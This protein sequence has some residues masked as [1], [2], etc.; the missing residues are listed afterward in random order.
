MKMMKGLE[1]VSYRERLREK[2]LFIL[3]NRGHREIFSMSINNS[4][5]EGKRDRLFSVMFGDRPRGSENK[6]K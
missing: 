4:E 1:H 3:D 2:R 6:L 5:G